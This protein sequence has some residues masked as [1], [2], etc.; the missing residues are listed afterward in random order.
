MSFIIALA[1]YHYMRLPARWEKKL[2]GRDDKIIQTT[3]KELDL[4]V[5]I[6]DIRD[7]SSLPF[8]QLQKKESEI[9]KIINNM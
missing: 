7:L 3:Q 1:G 9:A 6:L 2:R 4:A 5:R 8:N